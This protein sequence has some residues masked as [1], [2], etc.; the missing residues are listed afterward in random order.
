MSPGRQAAVLALSAAARRRASQRA[1]VQD[2]FVGQ[3]PCS[4]VSTDVLQKFRMGISGL[5]CVRSG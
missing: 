1:R 2:I 5:I 3:R 4:S